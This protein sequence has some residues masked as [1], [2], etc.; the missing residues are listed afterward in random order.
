M[1]ALLDF[2]W[3]LTEILSPYSEASDALRR[4]VLLVATYALDPVPFVDQNAEALFWQQITER[5]SKGNIFR[6]VNQFLNHC[7][8]NALGVHR[9][10]PEPCPNPLP[11][12]WQQ[13]L[14][15]SMNDLADWRCPQIVV[16]R[17]RLP[18]WAADG[19]E[20]R[21]RCDDKPG[22]MHP[23]LLV[24]V[25]VESYRD[26]AFALSDFDPWDLRRCHP[27]Q[28]G[29]RVNHPCVLPRPPVL[30]GV[31]LRDLGLKLADARRAGWHLSGSRYFIPAD[32]WAVD[33]V[34]KASW[35]IGNIFSEATLNGRTGPVDWFGNVWAWDDAERHW[36]VQLHGGAGAYVRVSHTGVEL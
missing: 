3:D 14:R 21:L 4:Y 27:P 11:V 29:G 36:D 17:T 15:D 33:D 19:G 2:P 24:G 9:A 28:A 20:V 12:P 23:R 25:E 32:S 31:Q 34:A 35:R 7:R 10:E 26:H 16:T 30:R 1:K 22:E 5:G 6:P 8:C 13:A 18:S